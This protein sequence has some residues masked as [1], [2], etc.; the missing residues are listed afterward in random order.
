MSFSFTNLRVPALNFNIVH[1]NITFHSVIMKRHNRMYS[2]VAQAKTMLLN[3]QYSVTISP[4]GLPCCY[5]VMIVDEITSWLIWGFFVFAKSQCRV[6]P[7]T[8]GQMFNRSGTS[9][10]QV[11][12]PSRTRS[13]LRINVH[14]VL[15]PSL[16]TVKYFFW[17]RRTRR[18]GLAWLPGS[19]LPTST[20][21]L[22][23]KQHPPSWAVC[24]PRLL[25]RGSFNLAS[26][27]TK[28]ILEKWRCFASDKWNWNPSFT[29][30]TVFDD[31]G[32][33][34]SRLIFVAQNHLQCPLYIIHSRNTTF[35]LYQH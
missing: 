4:E 12:F 32:F 20:A 26:P 35:S 8:R 3:K 31:S 28:W 29:C 10:W 24:A 27:T 25:Q 33:L 15:K 1:S 22:A 21:G 13:G 7:H 2:S 14:T 9:W 16:I 30:F 19:A 34:K 23:A 18:L 11:S 6:F 5:N 17:L